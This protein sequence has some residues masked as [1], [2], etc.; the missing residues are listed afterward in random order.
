VIATSFADLQKQFP[1]IIMGSYPFE[2]GTSLVFRATDL[3][4][5]KK[6]VAIMK[7]IVLSIHYQAII[8]IDE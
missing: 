6:T 8:K 1:E 5:L 3:A 2:G 7:D 4:M